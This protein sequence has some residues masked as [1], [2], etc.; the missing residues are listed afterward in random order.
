MS[1]FT[2]LDD[3][4]VW[5]IFMSLDLKA[6]LSMQAVN[7]VLKR[8]GRAAFACDTWCSL[9]HNQMARRVMEGSWTDDAA[10]EWET[11]PIVPHFPRTRIFN[12]DPLGTLAA[13]AG[14][15]DDIYLYT[16]NMHQRL[17]SATLQTSAEV[18]WLALRP[19]AERED[20]VA[21]TAPRLAASIGY[22]SEHALDEE[23]DEFDLG[24][25]S[26]CVWDIEGESPPPQPAVT[27]H[28]SNTASTVGW[29]GDERLIVNEEMMGR[30]V[31]LVDLEAAAV[32]E[33]E[34]GRPGAAAHFSNVVTTEGSFVY[35]DDHNLSLWSTD[36][37]RMS[38]TRTLDMCGSLPPDSDPY[39]PAFTLSAIDQRGRIASGN[40][41]GVI[42][43]WST[44]GSGTR[45]ATLRQPGA[46]NPV[47]S[48]A[49]NGSLLV[50][51]HELREEFPPSPPSDDD[52]HLGWADNPYALPRI[53]RTVTAYV[54]C[55]EREAVVAS[56]IC[57]GHAWHM[58]TR[59]FGGSLVMT[60]DGEAD[61]DPT[62]A[63]QCLQLWEPKLW[64]Q[65]R[66]GGVR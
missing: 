54:W 4:C 39:K 6:V 10:R 53:E 19:G 47:V 2:D 34:E 36:G 7:A 37:D 51:L 41:L 65:D 23:D 52:D 59:F 46:T 40:R 29:V 24:Q 15:D 38:L 27:I 66:S 28:S 21:P 33:Q 11:T 63:T 32:V 13:T 12:V 5:E 62:V 8:L 22:P 3:A 14:Q 18:L 55:L 30:G 17:W 25:A 20:D 16:G 45:L 1:S 35:E 61:C 56:F 31:C 60:C 49:L 50:S 43:L 64:W 9:Q 58:P 42:K 48:L 44:R 57:E 26:I